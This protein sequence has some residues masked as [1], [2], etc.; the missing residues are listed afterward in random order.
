MNAVVEPMRW[1][2]IPEVHAVEV[3]LFP[4]DPWSVEQF[5]QELAQPTRH[6]L[7][8]R[9]ES[10]IIGYAGAFVLA[11][12]ADV[13]TVGVRADRQGSG[14]ARLLLQDLL[15]EAGEGGAT[16]VMLEVR[17]DNAPA[18][19]LYGSLGFARI[20]ERRRYYPD[21]TDAVIMRRHVRDGPAR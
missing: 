19:A 7:V 14:V 12:D 20:S 13:Q 2:H 11:P 4:A 15:A 17:A 16:H 6:Y 3:D 21:G 1:W 9:D 8:V 18:I 5:W 10:G